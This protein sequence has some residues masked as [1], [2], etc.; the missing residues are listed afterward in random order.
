MATKKD[1]V[2]CQVCGKRMKLSF[3]SRFNIYYQ[4]KQGSQVSPY[5]EIYV[6][7]KCRVGKTVVFQGSTD[8][9][10]LLGAMGLK[11]RG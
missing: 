1:I 9:E 6:C 7:S 2:F 3:R 5:K 4:V 10:D 11:T 8:I